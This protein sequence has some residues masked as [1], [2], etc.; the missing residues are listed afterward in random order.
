MSRVFIPTTGLTA[1]LSLSQLS[2]R[3]ADAYHCTISILLRQLTLAVTLTTTL[4]SAVVS[5]ERRELSRMPTLQ[6]ATTDQSAR[7]LISPSAHVSPFGS[8]PTATHSSAA[9]A[10]DHARGFGSGGPRAGRS[11][12]PRCQSGG[13]AGS[14]SARFRWRRRGPLETRILRARRAQ[15]APD[16]TAQA[17]GAP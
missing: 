5:L 4:I 16:R 8:S 3:R 7:M 11:V 17:A 2:D 6:V 15:G 1:C 12:Y 9:S 10:P 14:E 13:S